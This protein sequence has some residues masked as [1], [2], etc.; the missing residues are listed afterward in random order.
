MI[1]WGL[2]GTCRPP[3]DLDPGIRSCLLMVCPFFTPSVFLIVH[4]TRCPALCGV[5]WRLADQTREIPLRADGTAPQ[6]VHLRSL[7]NTPVTPS[8][9]C[10]TKHRPTLRAQGI[11]IWNVICRTMS[12]PNHQERSIRHQQGSTPALQ[13]WRRH[14]RFRGDHPTFV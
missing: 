9:R 14:G 8:T 3:R 2:K 10:R 5:M 7:K 13:L 1:S 4:C 12:K 11:T 6:S